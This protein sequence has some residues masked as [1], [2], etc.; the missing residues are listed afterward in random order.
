MGF[1]NV[2]TEKSLRFVI[3]LNIFDGFTGRFDNGFIGNL[4]IFFGDIFDGVFDDNLLDSFIF[5]K[6]GFTVS[7]AFSGLTILVFTISVLLTFVGAG[8]LTAGVPVAFDESNVV[9]GIEIGDEFDIW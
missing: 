6:N 1:D 4:I 3:T 8:V 7:S 2:E 5:L 9:F